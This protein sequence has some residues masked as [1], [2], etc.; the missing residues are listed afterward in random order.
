MAVSHYMIWHFG[1]INGPWLLPAHR[2]YEQGGTVLLATGEDIVLYPRPLPPLPNQREDGLQ[3]V[4]DS[5]LVAVRVVKL[6]NYW[7]QGCMPGR[8]FSL[9][10]IMADGSYDIELWSPH[11]VA[12][13]LAVISRA[14]PHWA[15]A[16]CASGCEHH[17]VN[18]SGCP[19]CSQSIVVT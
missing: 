2:F 12:A 15:R 3:F 11:Y 5:D 1:L 6:L 17:F 9:F 7:F 10:K 8:Y 13:S 18:P 19:E 4:A 16:V 14:N